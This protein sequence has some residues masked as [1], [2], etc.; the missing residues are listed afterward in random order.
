MAAGG[1]RTSCPRRRDALE[2]DK[3]GDLPGLF[4]SKP[5]LAFVFIALGVVTLW[6]MLVG[7]ALTTL[8]GARFDP[9]LM[10]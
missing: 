9:Q 5:I 6:L 1:L 10:P 3:P 4:H 8:A 2:P 7:D